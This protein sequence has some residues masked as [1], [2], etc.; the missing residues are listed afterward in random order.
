MCPYPQSESVNKDIAEHTYVLQI[1]IQS[2]YNSLDL[3]A[4]IFVEFM[5]FLNQ[6]K[7]L[8]LT[9]AIGIGADLIGVQCAPRVRD[10]ETC[11]HTCHAKWCTRQT[12]PLV[13]C[14]STN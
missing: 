4:E 5:T 14:G 2:I 9:T 6:R 12:L 11:P 10:Q 13:R 7:Q 8:S 1:L 3:N